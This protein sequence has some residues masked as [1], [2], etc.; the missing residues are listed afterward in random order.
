[1]PSFLRLLPLLMLP[2]ALPAASVSGEFTFETKVPLVGLVWVD[3][4]ASP[5]STVKVGQKGRT[6]SPGLVFAPAGSTLS[7]Q[8]DDDQDHNAYAKD[9]ALDADL[10]LASPGKEIVQ[11]ISW[12]DGTFVRF[13]CKIHPTMQLWVGSVASPLAVQPTFNK[14]EHSG[15]VV[16]ANI[17]DGAA[18][19]HVWLPLHDPLTLTVAGTPVSSD[20]LLKGRKTGSVTLTMTP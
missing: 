6:F 12:A 15:K 7:I 16:I 14:E 17:P 13:G 2:L 8:N 5:A 1:M 11:K 18:T 19:V 4:A 10:G 20:L 9:P 3:A